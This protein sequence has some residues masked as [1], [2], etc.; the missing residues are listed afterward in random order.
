VYQVDDLGAL[1]VYAEVFGITVNAKGYS[2]GMGVKDGTG[3]KL[4]LPVVLP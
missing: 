2:L 4:A 3:A 1:V